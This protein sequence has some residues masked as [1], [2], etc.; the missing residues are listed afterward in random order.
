M[1]DVLGWLAQYGGWGFLIIVLLI[2]ALCYEKFEKPVAKVYDLLSQVST[3]WRRRAI[4]TEIQSNINSF[5]RSIDKEVPNTM[6]YNMELKFVTDVERAELLKT[7]N[8]ILVR[9][10]DRKHDDK[11]I[12]HAMLAFCPVGVLPTS[13]IYLDDCLGDAIDFTVTRKLLSATQHQSAI[14]YLHREVIEPAIKEKPDLD[15]IC[16]ILD[17]FDDQGLFT[18]VVLRELR[19]FGAKVGSRYPTETHKS[20]TRQFVEYMD[21]IAKRQPG[22]KCET[23][24][25]GNCIS[26]IF[27]MVGTADKL[28]TKGITGYLQAIQWA[29]GR[30]LG[31]VYIAARDSLI[32]EAERTAYLAQKRGLGKIVGKPKIY[33]AT[34][35]RGLRRKNVLIEMQLITSPFAPPEQGKLIE[36]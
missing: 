34:D 3:R 21:V 26:M 13:R 35:I 12:V 25:N 16:R 29:R 9:I 2:F 7:K 24:F 20:E 11:N 15:N 32:S 18:K 22:E 28:A 17:R 4:K 14:T 5:S 31:R 30:G 36:D 23:S 8:M 1:D 10:R 33:E 19:D 6:P 27:L